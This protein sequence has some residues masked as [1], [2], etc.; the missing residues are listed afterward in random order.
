[1][2]AADDMK[3]RVSRALC[4]MRRETPMGKRVASDGRNT[5]VV[6]KICGGY[7]AKLKTV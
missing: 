3:W 1:M 2:I 4:F 7:P 6:S 5:I